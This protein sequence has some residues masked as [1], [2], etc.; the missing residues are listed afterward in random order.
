MTEEKGL[1]HSG[2]LLADAMRRVYSEAVQGAIKPLEDD[3]VVRQPKALDSIKVGMTA[4]TP[5]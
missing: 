4:E 2:G 3:C 1:N 5:A